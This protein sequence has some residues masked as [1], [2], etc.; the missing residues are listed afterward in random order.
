MKTSIQRL[1]FAFLIAALAGLVSTAMASSPFQISTS[2]VNADTG[3]PQSSFQPGDNV[4]ISV[5]ADIPSTAKNKNLRV[6]F[7]AKAS[8]YGFEFPVRLLGN[9]SISND[10]S[11]IDPSKSGPIFQSGDEFIRFRIPKET[12]TST[13]EVTI[14][15]SIKNVGKATSVTIIPVHRP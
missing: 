15:A 9:S 14:K 5:T 12:P 6:S 8:A 13:L 2:V 7:S 10:L 1:W 11:V 3:L 4:A